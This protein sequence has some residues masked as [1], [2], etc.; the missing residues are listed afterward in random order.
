MG[1]WKRSEPECRWHAIFE[2]Q[3]EVVAE[4]CRSGDYLAQFDMALLLGHL[5]RRKIKTIWIVARSGEI[6]CTH[7]EVPAVIAD[8]QALERSARPTSSSRRGMATASS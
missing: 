3:P 6:I 5:D 1:L 8:R 7:G 2:D 4:V